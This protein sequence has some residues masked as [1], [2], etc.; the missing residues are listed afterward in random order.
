MSQH[1]RASS[2]APEDVRPK[3]PS[4][5]KPQKEM[6]ILPS[7]SKPPLSHDYQTMR[8]HLQDRPTV[9]HYTPRATTKAIPPN[10]VDRGPSRTRR[11]PLKKALRSGSYNTRPRPPRQLRV[12][13]APTTRK[14]NNSRKSQSRQDKWKYRTPDSALK[15]KYRSFDAGREDFLQSISVT[16]SDITEHMHA[17]SG[18]RMG[19]PRHEDNGSRTPLDCFSQEVHDMQ[20]ALDFLEDGGHG[21]LPKR[22]RNGIIRIAFENWNSLGVHTNSWKIDKLNGLIRRLHLDIVAACEVQCDWRFCSPPKQFM[23]LVAPGY[24][25]RGVAGHNITG[26]MR[27][28]DQFGGTAIVALGRICDVVTEVGKDDS[29]LGRWVWLRLH[30]TGGPTTYIVSAYFPHR[31]R[32]QGS[33]HTVEYQHSLYYQSI[34]DFR[35]PPIIF[36][37][38]LLHLLRPW[39]E[40]GHKIILSM[41]ANQ[42]VYTGPISKELSQSP[43]HMTCMFQDTLGG[44]V[45]NSHH[46]GTTPITTMF[47]SPGLMV[48]NAMVFPHWYGLGDH[49]LFV[50]WTISEHRATT[51]TTP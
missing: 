29:G 48:E 21:H 10:I 3:M 39:R 33:S 26:R 35:P 37:E 11:L 7:D 36:T 12:A 14:S 45:P 5:L 27:R 9:P 41:D 40:S 4:K 22:K 13:P 32:S 20:R 24:E 6:T 19:I 31:T 42:H 25:K 38:D 28:R 51:G 23:Q 43:F 47:G 50:W 18:S 16:H 15:D 46:R 34:G 30:S 2:P 8:T 1:G 49:R 44:P 17:S